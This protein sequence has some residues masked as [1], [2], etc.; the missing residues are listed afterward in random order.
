VNG[1]AIDTSNFGRVG[2]H[3]MEPAG[4]LDR[5][6]RPLS[7]GFGPSGCPS[8]PLVS[9]QINRQLSGR[10]PPP[11]VTR[12]FGAA[13]RRLK[14]SRMVTCCLTLIVARHT[15]ERADHCCGGC[16]IPP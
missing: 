4:S 14:C 15:A 7:R 1:E 9:Y 16:G 6:K 3:I 11:L 10:N 13:L 2:I 8:K 5:H 12:A